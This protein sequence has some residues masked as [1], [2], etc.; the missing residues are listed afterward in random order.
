MAIAAMG[1][2]AILCEYY[3]AGYPG[4]WPGLLVARVSS[5]GL[6]SHLR[7]NDNSTS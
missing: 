4:G 6:D 2:L 1:G 5:D 3:L 7:E